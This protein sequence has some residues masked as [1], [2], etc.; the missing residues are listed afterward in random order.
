LVFA[1]GQAH[2]VTE[3]EYQ[4][5]REFSSRNNHIQININNILQKIMPDRNLKPIY[6]EEHEP[7]L[8]ERKAMQL[9]RLGKFN[10]VDLTLESGGKSIVDD[11]SNKAVK[12]IEDIIDH[13]SN[14]KYKT[15]NIK[16]DMDKVFSVKNEKVNY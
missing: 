4:L 5:N 13:I 12:N 1:K 15:V 14:K 11:N 6:K 3:K 2:P 8:D 7:N 10:E 9:L 16:H